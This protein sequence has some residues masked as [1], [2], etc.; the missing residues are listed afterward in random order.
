MSKLIYFAFRQPFE[1]AEMLA[2]FVPNLT[3]EVIADV[4]V[5]KVITLWGCPTTVVPD[6]GCAIFSK[7]SQAVH[8]LLR[9]QIYASVIFTPGCRIR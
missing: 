7:L 3:V 1:S 2:F 9:V 6:N 5:N 4:L 8:R